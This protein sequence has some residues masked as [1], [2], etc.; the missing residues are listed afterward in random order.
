MY[1]VVG[2]RYGI[3][4]AGRGEGTMLT[5]DDCWLYRND[6]EYRCHLYIY[7]FDTDDDNKGLTTFDEPGNNFSLYSSLGLEIG[8]RRIRPYVEIRGNLGQLGVLSQAYSYNEYG[9]VAGLRF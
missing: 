9:L 7:E 8:E 3:L 1:A 5:V 6:D 2:L 4:L